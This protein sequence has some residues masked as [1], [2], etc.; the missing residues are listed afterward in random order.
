[1][2][3]VD[4][5]FILSIIKNKEHTTAE[6]QRLLKPYLGKWMKVSGPVRDV[7]ESTLTLANYI[8][9]AGLLDVFLHFDSAWSE[10]PAV[11][12]VGAPVTV[13]GQIVQADRMALRLKHCEL[14]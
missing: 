1:V 6:M 9:S 5:A 10:R 11:Q 13:L 8:T 2:I 4:A 7:S 12:R 14:I 3:D